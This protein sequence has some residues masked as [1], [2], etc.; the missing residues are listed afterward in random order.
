MP[1]PKLFTGTP[2]FYI[3]FYY[4]IVYQQPDPTGKQDKNTYYHFT[5]HGDVFFKNIYDTPYRTNKTDN[6]NNKW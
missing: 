2:F 4:K 1:L 5:S 3:V 6:V